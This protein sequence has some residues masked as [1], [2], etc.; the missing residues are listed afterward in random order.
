MEFSA[1][2]HKLPDDD[3]VQRKI[4]FRDK[5]MG[6]Q[7]PLARLEKMNLIEKNLFKIELQDDDRLK[8]RCFLDENVVKGLR[9]P[10]QDAVVIKLLDKKIGYNTMM[11][12]L[13]AM[14]KPTGG[15]EIVDVA[16]I[17]SW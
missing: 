1:K 12:K 5:L 15:I 2:P 16:M 8:P 14:W 7:E 17:S 11:N 6:G 4:S 9:K 3:I 13:Y 10:L